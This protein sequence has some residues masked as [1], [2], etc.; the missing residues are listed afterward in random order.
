MALLRLRK[1]IGEPVSTHSLATYVWVSA[2]GVHVWVSTAFQ[3]GMHWS[4]EDLGLCRPGPMQI[5]AYA[6][7]QPCS[8]LNMSAA[9]VGWEQ[10]GMLLDRGGDCHGISNVSVKC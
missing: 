3:R 4:Y 6:D 9:E 5:W 1:N 10:H 8:A 2:G 7:L